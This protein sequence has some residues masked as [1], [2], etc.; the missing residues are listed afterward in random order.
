MS[1]TLQPMQQFAKTLHIA[2][3]TVDRSRIGSSGRIDPGVAACCCISAQHRSR[4]FH[5]R[6]SMT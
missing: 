2:W 4:R 3:A 1:S 6:R 5:C